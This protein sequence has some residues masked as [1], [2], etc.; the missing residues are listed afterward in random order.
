MASYVSPVL[1]NSKMKA[2][3][4]FVL[5]ALVTD[6]SNS[7]HYPCPRNEMGEKV[8][9]SSRILETSLGR[10]I[11]AWKHLYIHQLLL[12][13]YQVVTSPLIVVKFFFFF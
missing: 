4:D 2:M 3:L 1:E 13:N 5:P 11:A 9:D 10:N 8:E 12:T 6:T 7:D